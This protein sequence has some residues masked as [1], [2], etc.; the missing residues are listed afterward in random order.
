MREHPEVWKKRE[1]PFCQKIL[2][3]AVSYRKHLKAMHSN[4]NTEG[5]TDYPL[6]HKCSL[7]GSQFSFRESFIDHINGH[8][9]YSSKEVQ[10][11]RKTHCYPCKICKS[12]FAYKFAVMKHV[13]LVHMEKG[14]ECQECG[15]QFTH[16]GLREHFKNFHKVFECPSCKKGLQGKHFYH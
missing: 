10:T 16:L 9:Q 8:L 13:A 3:T 6:F 4:G 1:C 7:C 12:E 2:F 15:M 5:K 11:Y 14:R